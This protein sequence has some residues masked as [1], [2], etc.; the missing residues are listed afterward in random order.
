[1][2]KQ[3][4]AVA[5]V[6][7]VYYQTNSQLEETKL[8][9]ISLV[10]NTFKYIFFLIIIFVV[11]DLGKCQSYKNIKKQLTQKKYFWGLHIAWQMHPKHEQ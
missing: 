5:A 6:R 1:M 9:M 7:L 10:Q 11:V 3:N 8:Y 2:V 4:L